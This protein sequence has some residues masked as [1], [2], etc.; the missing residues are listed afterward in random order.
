[1]F[2][3]PSRIDGEGL[4]MAKKQLKIVRL[5]EPELCLECRFSQMAAVEQADGTT[6]RMIYCRR[7]DCDNWDTSEAEIANDVHLDDAA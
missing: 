6:S 2:Y 7:R 5:I 3:V 4:G 1:M